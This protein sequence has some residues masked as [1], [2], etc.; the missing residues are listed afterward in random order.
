M[1]NN[2]KLI[3]KPA[4]VFL[5]AV[6]MW[7]GK[8]QAQV[9]AN[10]I[11]NS[12]P[13]SYLSDWNNGATGQLIVTNNTATAGL[14]V[15]IVAQLQD[16]GGSPFAIS[17]NGSAQTYTLNSGANIIAINR[18]LQLENLRFTSNI[19][20]LSNSGKLPAGQ[21]FVSVNVINADNG[22]SL[23]QQ[24]V[25]KP[26]T[27]INYQLPYLLSP[28]DN[29]SLNANIA[30]TAITFRWSNLIPFTQDLGIYRLQVFEIMED[31]KPLQALLSNQPILVTD[32]RLVTQY[33]W[34]PQIGF[35]DGREHKF[36]WTIQTID[37]KGMPY[38]TQDANNKGRS[39]PR[40]FSV[41]NKIIK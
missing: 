22:S 8:A 21:Y 27:Q 38:A 30:Q 37:S 6:F 28:N 35:K 40:T 20:S 3:I 17:N 26:F 31:Q 10:L 23:L 19:N 25:T 24:S 14:R 18:V 5:I 39:E 16:A 11:L 2:M 12:R 9:T 1:N 36:I 4:I 29:D 34:R 32:L 41:V 33:I 15:K 13:P 7:G